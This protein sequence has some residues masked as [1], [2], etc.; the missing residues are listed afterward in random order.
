MSIVEKID[1]VFQG[2]FERL[3]SL[4]CFSESD[5]SNMMQDSKTKVIEALAERTMTIA[6]DA[7]MNLKSL[8]MTT[9]SGEVCFAPNKKIR[10]LV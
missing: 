3:I 1:E 9:T 8:C 5:L 7:V 10:T 6:S 4:E 2:L